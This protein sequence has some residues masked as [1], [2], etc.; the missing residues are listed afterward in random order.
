MASEGEVNTYGVTKSDTGDA[1]EQTE[2]KKTSKGLFGFGVSSILS[3]IQLFSL[4]R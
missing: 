4:P 3:E 1:E 2:T